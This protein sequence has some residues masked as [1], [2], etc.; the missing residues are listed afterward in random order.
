M[1][2][3]SATPAFLA[4]RQTLI[5]GSDAASLFNIGYG[6]KRRLVYRKRD[7]APDY[8]RRDSA[9]MR[10]GRRLEHIAAEEYAIETGREVI[11]ESVRRHP[12]FP[13][14]GVH[15][16]RLIRSADRQDLGVLEIKCVGREM[17]GKI[18]R[19]GMVDDYVLQVQHGMLVTGATW[20]AFAVFWADGLDLLS[21]DV[22]RDDAICDAL[23]EE[24]RAAW[25]VI[26]D[27]T[28]DLPGRLDLPDKRCSHCEYRT[29]CQGQA[30]LELA[31]E[32]DGDI[33]LDESLDGIVA[34]YFE[35]AEAAGE[36]EELLKAKKEDLRQAV[37]DR[38]AVDATGAR[39]Y[40]RPQTS[41]RGDFDALAAEYERVR[42]ALKKLAAEL[43]AR[44][45]E[46]ATTW[47]EIA[48]ET[49][50]PA[51]AFKRPSVTRPLRVY[52]R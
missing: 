19:E 14:V 52:P 24:S 45:P 32:P 1:T 25:R 5:G 16:D 7:I 47:M 11:T 10:R 34:E 6:C 36:A 38:T 9:P 2:S 22:E 40:Y 20:G 49:E 37:G 3:E 33:P 29:R 30:L 35:A 46:R 26:Q 50:R 27:P 18:K 39:I 44:A 51:K 8:P 48:G 31:G 41:M 28:M 42:Q 15:V 13:F 12:E 23:L 17:F 21:W 4:E 43:L